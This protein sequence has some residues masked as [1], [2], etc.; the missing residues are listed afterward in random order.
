MRD[1]I[2][3]GKFERTNIHNEFLQN[4]DR[5]MIR[6]MTLEKIVEEAK[7]ERRA[8]IAEVKGCQ[9]GFE[10]VKLRQEKLIRNQTD[11]LKNYSSSIKT[12]EKRLVKIQE[13]HD[14]KYY[15]QVAMLDLAM[16][17]FKNK[18]QTNKDMLL[19]VANYLQKTLPIV[20]YN[21]V[22]DVLNHNGIL[23]GSSFNAFV[24]K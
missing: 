24:E 1:L 11:S 3:L 2:D 21:I 12:M 22:A 4:H 13:T 5:A 16:R 10:F 23:K 20:N 7:I 15:G 14:E 19:S 6:M 18:A 17:D 8:C 9:E